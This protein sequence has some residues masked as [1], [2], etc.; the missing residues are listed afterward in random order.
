MDVKLSNAPDSIQSELVEAQL[1]H[2]AQVAN[3]LAD[4]A[5]HVIR[6]YFRKSF[7]ILD[8]EDLSR[9]SCSSFSRLIISLAKCLLTE[10]EF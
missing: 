3:K 10:D 4:A 1:D 5:G 2:F 6:K 8:K 9:F 7:E